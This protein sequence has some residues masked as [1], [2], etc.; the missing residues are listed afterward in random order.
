MASRSITPEIIDCARR[1]FGCDL[2]FLS[3]TKKLFGTVFPVIQTDN[4]EITI[5]LGRMAKAFK[6][7]MAVSPAFFSWVSEDIEDNCKNIIEKAAEA[8]TFDIEKNHHFECQCH[9]D[10]H[11]LSFVYFQDEAPSMREVYCNIFLDKPDFW[12]RLVQGLKYI[13]GINTSKYGH[14]HT[15]TLKAED[16]DRM[17]CV[18]AAYRKDMDARFG[19]LP[20]REHSDEPKHKNVQ[21]NEDRTGTNEGGHQ[22]SV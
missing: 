20:E 19:Y 2:V 10:E 4:G 16:I 3:R 14:F 6:E 11:R 8:G 9:S 1:F 21:G 22:A 17:L 15:W 7:H 18:L 12:G 13:L 5:R